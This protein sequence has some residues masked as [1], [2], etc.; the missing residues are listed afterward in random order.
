MN[1]NKYLLQSNR[2]IFYLISYLIIL[3][4]NERYLRELCTLT[5]K[6]K[7]EILQEMQEVGQI[8]GT[9]GVQ[10]Y[11][12]S[13][14]L[15]INQVQLKFIVK[16]VSKVKWKSKS[17][18]VKIFIKELEKMDKTITVEMLGLLTLLT[19]Y[20]NYEDNSLIN[21]DGSYLNQNDI[22]NLT[23]WGRKKVNQTLKVLIDNEI[24]QTKKQKEDL[25]K[26]KYF[27]NPNY[28]YKGQ[29]IDPEIKEYYGQQSK[30]NK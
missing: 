21:K 18:F 20:L 6:N 24:L 5:N 14:G 7:K 3:L 26:S 28:F 15:D 16:D 8:I 12:E 23:G 10:D 27:I 11:L 30:K 4:F 19:P 22:M 17:E 13:H 9:N 1:I 29:K 25:R 2:V